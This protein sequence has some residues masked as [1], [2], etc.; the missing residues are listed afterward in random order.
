MGRTAENPMLGWNLSN[1][2]DTEAGCNLA[3]FAIF[4]REYEMIRIAD[5]VR[6]LIPAARACGMF[7]AWA[8][9]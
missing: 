7:I 4:E 8:T 3:K 9:P 1:R 6:P 5:A 2:A